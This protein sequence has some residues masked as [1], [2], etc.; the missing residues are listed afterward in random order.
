MY[1]FSLNRKS[2]PKKRR[3]DGETQKTENRFMFD[4]H[5][6]LLAG[7]SQMMPTLV[8]PDPKHWHLLFDSLILHPKLLISKHSSRFEMLKMK[9]YTEYLDDN[10]A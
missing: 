5:N 4:Y 1:N 10:S 9:L 7:S 3:R 8:D 6:F 2:F